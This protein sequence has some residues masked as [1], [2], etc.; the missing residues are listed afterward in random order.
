MKILRNIILLC[1]A[2]VLNSLVYS[3]PIQLIS[4][5]KLEIRYRYENDSSFLDLIQRWAINSRYELTF[6]GRNDLPVVPELRKVQAITLREALE[7]ALDSYKGY[8]LNVVML[9]RIDDKNKHV[10]LSSVTPEEQAKVLQPKTTD[11]AVYET[12]KSLM[13]VLVRWANQAGYQTMINE[14][15]VNL[16]AFPRHPTRYADFTLIESAKKFK[17]QSSLKEAAGQL[18]IL[19]SGISLSPF[20]IRVDE[21]A[22]QMKINS[23]S[24]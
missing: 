2:A 18:V 13:Q 19:Y 14:Q 23:L 16:D 12:D 1:S 5:P 22:K 8:N 6:T 9:A 7:K 15:P 20:T 10:Y 21:L 3:Q 4:T 24:K 11:F 17:T